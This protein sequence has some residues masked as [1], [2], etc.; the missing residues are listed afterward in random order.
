MTEE[1][2]I[3]I[4]GIAADR[5]VNEKTNFIGVC[6]ALS[7]AYRDLEY[8]EASDKWS[9][10]VQTFIRHMQP[11]YEKK[12]GGAYWIGYLSL[13][14]IP[15]RLKVLQEFKDL[16]INNGEYKQFNAR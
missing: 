6:H 10:I 4:V 12:E 11:K 3:K 14:N 2:F 9:L 5:I 16:I 1:K 13:E 8:L 7:R 15:L